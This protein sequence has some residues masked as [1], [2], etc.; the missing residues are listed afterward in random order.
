MI[1]HYSHFRQGKDFARNAGSGS[2]PGRSR[3]PEAETIRQIAKM[4]NPKHQPF[5]EHPTPAFPRAALGLPIITHFQ[6]GHGERDPDDS[7]LLPYFGR[8]LQT[9]MASPLIL[10]PLILSDAKKALPLII[11][12]GGP[13]PESLALMIQKKE[14]KISY[15]GNIINNSAFAQYK[16]SPLKEYAGKDVVD[17]CIEH[18]K[19]KFNSKD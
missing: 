4:R 17:A 18:L 14:K 1:S 7:E 16:D 5:P 2:R 3:W 8:E 10:K 9:R 11:R 12:L 6:N 15:E 19:K 13:E